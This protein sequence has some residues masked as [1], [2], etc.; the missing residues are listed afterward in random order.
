MTELGNGQWMG[1]VEGDAPGIG[2]L[3]LDD[4]GGHIAGHAYHFPDDPTL[5]SVAAEISISGRDL[6]QKI[7]KAPLKPVDPTLGV[8]LFPRDVEHHFPNTIVA[9]D[10]A[11][12]MEFTDNEVQFSY[13][14]VVTKGQGT[15]IKSQ[16]DAP[17]T[18]VPLN[19]DSWREFRDAAFSAEP[20]RFL[21]RGQDIQSRLRTSF[22]RTKRKNLA[23][24][25]DKDIA[26]LRRV[27][28][29]TLKHVFN[30][31][32]S[33]QTGAFY[34]LA[35]HHGY[36]T[37]LLDWSLSPFV[38]A[39][40]AFRARPGKR[41]NADR[42][43]LFAFDQ[44]EWRKDT[45]QLAGV[46]YSKPHFS[47]IELLAIENARMVPQQATAT[48]TNI[49]DIESYIQWMG[50]NRGKTYLSAIDI[51]LSERAAAL[52]DLDMMGINAGSLF[53]GIEGACEALSYK[54]FGA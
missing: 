12:T 29:P 21:Y 47:I 24:Y 27:L 30:T 11:I 52:S 50:Q 37:P 26:D 39:F 43:R 35:Q 6:I 38:A 34:N 36:P 23:V 40:F 13:E 17:S 14:T 19:V 2:V 53:P 25:R 54:N 16:A 28:S 5:P 20:D 44:R 7:E 22:H 45:A 42:V 10:A 33:A 15:L 49:D 46:A 51:P 41:P 8:W 3:E 32:D 1:R 48:I 18:L 9:P 4:Y 31:Q